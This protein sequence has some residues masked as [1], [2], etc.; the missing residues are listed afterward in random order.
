MV[1][2]INLIINVPIFGCLRRYS[3]ILAIRQGRRRCVRCQL[4]LF[5]RG[6]SADSGKSRII[7]RRIRQARNFAI[8]TIVDEDTA[9]LNRL[10]VNDR[11][12]VAIAFKGY[13]V[14]ANSYGRVVTHYRTV[15]DG[16]RRRAVLCYNQLIVDVHQRVAFFR[17]TVEHDLAV[18]QFDVIF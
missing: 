4:Q 3:R 17:R 9:S 7:Q 11:A 2:Q 6:R 5:F 16:Y 10:T 14:G 15:V 8:A 1:I 18:A 13:A 12:A